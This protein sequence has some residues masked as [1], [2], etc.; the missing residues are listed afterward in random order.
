MKTYDINVTREGKW[1]MIE[2]PEIDGLTQARR[3]SEIEDMARSFIA[4]D[5]DTPISEVAIR[6]G[7]IKVG[8]LGDIAA[9][10]RRI[11]KKREEIEAAAVVAQR[12]LAELARALTEAEVPVR[13]SATLLDVSPQRV[14]QLS[15]V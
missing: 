7:G 5:T 13:D 10:A 14:S 9:R 4:V 12:D 1:W 3:V 15:N 11:V 6:V 8:E 2:I